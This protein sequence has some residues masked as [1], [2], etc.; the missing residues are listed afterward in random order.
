MNLGSWRDAIPIIKQRPFA[1][2]R[3]LG[4]LYEFDHG[5]IWQPADAEPQIFRWDQVATVNWFASRRYVN[6]AYTGTMFWLTLA[7][8]DGRSQKFS[9]NCKDPAAKGARNADPRAHDYLLYQFLSRARDTISSAQLPAAVAALNRGEE[10]TFGDLRLSTTG[11]AAPKGFVPW[12]SIKAVNI[13]Q[14]RV[15][16][17][18]E[19]KFFS[20]SSQGAEKIPNCP[21]FLTLAQALTRQ[22]ATA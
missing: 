19:G 6:G 22:A 11:I 21:L 15:S 4:Y 5:F 20:L 9:G 14:G 17:R 18:Q 1:A 3:I 8:N 2:A 13:D 10:L 16:V 12:T 7:A